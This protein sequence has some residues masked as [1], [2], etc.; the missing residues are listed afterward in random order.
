MAKTK[1]LV[2]RTTQVIEEVTYYSCSNE[3]YDKLKNAKDDEEK[4]KIWKQL[5]L[6]E[7]PDILGDNTDT[8]ITEIIDYGIHHD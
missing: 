5:T 8:T 2:Y 6:T 3:V 1:A 4:Y 7:H